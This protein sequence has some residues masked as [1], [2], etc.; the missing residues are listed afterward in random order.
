M[1]YY[2]NFWKMSDL[3]TIFVFVIVILFLFNS[4][5]E[6]QEIEAR[7]DRELAAAYYE[8][9]QERERKEAEDRQ[10]EKIIK[11]RKEIILEKI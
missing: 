2:R 5:S 1:H 11:T 9:I 4:L 7:R 3:F 6:L 8:Q 10:W